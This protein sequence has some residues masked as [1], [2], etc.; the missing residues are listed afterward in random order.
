[1][2]ISALRLMWMTELIAMKNKIVFS[3]I[4]FLCSCADKETGYLFYDNISAVQRDERIYPLTLLKTNKRI[5]VLM[6][7]DNSG[8]M[9]TIH[10]NVIVN[11]E[12]FF[13]QFALRKKVEWK[14]GIISTDRKQKPFLGFEL[15]FSSKLIH[16][17]KSFNMAVQIFQDAVDNLGTNG[18]D[19]ELVFL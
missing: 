4:F 5:D 16:N 13:K 14:L 10:N 17:K 11:A 19:K 15:D 9:R 6:V 3:L 8:S 1:M 12:L 2:T 18:S 7:I